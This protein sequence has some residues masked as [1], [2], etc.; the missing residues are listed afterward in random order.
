MVALNGKRKQWA[1]P[2]EKSASD[3]R[4][5]DVL[6]QIKQGFIVKP[7]GMESEYKTVFI[8]GKKVSVET[9][10]I[11]SKKMIRFI[12]GN[13]DESKFR[14]TFKNPSINTGSDCQLL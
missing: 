3:R 8:N 9:L 1:N 12:E 13:V 4:K 6:R 2:A 11:N 10:M 7:D 5:T 14:N